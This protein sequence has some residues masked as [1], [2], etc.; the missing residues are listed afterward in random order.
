M[1]KIGIIGLGDIARKA[2]LPVVS[3]KNIDVHLYTR[4][5]ATLTAV[6]NQYRIKNLHT[7]MTSLIGSGIT[8]AFVHS[9]TST[10]NQIVEQL[11]SNNIHVYVDKPITYDYASSENL[12]A[13]AKRK[14]LILMT[15]FNRRF[16]P[17][18][19]A[20]KT[21]HEPNMI[22]MQK[23]RHALPAE[24]RTFV[25]DDFIHIVDTLLYLFPYPAERI[26]ISGRKKENLLYHVMVQFIAAEGQTAIG[27]MNRDSGTV[28]EKLEIFSSSEKRVVYD[29]A[30]MT[31]LKNKDETFSGR[32]DWES[33][34]HKRGFEQ[35]VNA[36][37]TAI[38]SGS[39]AINQH[40]ALL[41]HKICEQVVTVLN[42][43][44]P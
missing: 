30:E 18:Y 9:P 24:V 16:A 32:S 36:F 7:S 8:G 1:L 27:I 37:L 4:N 20:L 13:L 42:E 3:Q 33:T 21:L 14:K 28:E 10:H 2:Y 38:E 34:L 19:Q 22:I 6:G 43:K 11:L 40:D 12:L 41:T 44:H 29:L 35:I 39:P 26:L 23:N 25:F 15:G 5:E 31:I 17:A